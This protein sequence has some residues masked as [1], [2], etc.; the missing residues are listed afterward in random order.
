MSDKTQKLISDSLETDQ[1]LLP[2]MPYLLQDLWALGS[3]VEDILKAVDSLPLSSDSRVLDLGCGK[4]AVSVLIA[5]R[6]KCRVTGID[7]MAVAKKIKHFPNHHP[8]MRIFIR[9]NGC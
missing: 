1:Q 9:F 3:S 8:E 2:Y 5:S 7:A 4:G 6:F